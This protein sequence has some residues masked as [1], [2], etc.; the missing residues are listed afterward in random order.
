MRGKYWVGLGAC[1]QLVR[2]YERALGAYALAAVTSRPRDPLP[3]FHAGECYLA[4][5]NLRDAEKAFRM[6]VDF[7]AS[8]PE[9]ARLVRRAG[10]LLELIRGRSDHVRH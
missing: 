9:S 2:Q 4:L 10:A 8:Q 5:N 3:H 7:G 6:A 1:L